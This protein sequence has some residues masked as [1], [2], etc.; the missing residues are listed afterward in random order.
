VSPTAAAV[1]AG[2]LND[3]AWARALPRT[4]VAP[5]PRGVTGV[6]RLVG[7]QDAGAGANEAHD[8]TEIVHTL[9]EVP[10]TLIVT[11]SPDV[12]VALGV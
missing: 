2:E 8:A 12:A 10:S 1:G 5:A 7:I 9:D 6:T 11:V 4:T 3:T